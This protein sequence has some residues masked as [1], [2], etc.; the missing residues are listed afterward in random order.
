MFLLFFLD[1]CQNLLNICKKKMFQVLQAKSLYPL[2]FC[3]IPIVAT[4]KKKRYSAM[5]HLFSYSLYLI[6]GNNVSWYSCVYVY[7]I[8]LYMYLYFTLKAINSL[9]FSC[10]NLSDL[11]LYYFLINIDGQPQN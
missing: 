10:N 6:Y 3:S 1:K 9:C 2:I 7:L 5:K 8:Y 4:F 11:H